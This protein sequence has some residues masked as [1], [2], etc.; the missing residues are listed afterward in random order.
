MI[1]TLPSPLLALAAAMVR[2]HP[3]YDPVLSTGPRYVEYFH[4]DGHIEQKAV[5]DDRNL[6]AKFGLI[7]CDLC[8]RFQN[9][10]LLNTRNSW[11]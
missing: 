5:F 6:I 9:F 1:D 11:E 8:H 3:D 10:I 7:N 2:K 4:H